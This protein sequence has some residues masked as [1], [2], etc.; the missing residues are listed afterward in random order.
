V[1]WFISIYFSI[2]NTLPKS[3]TF[4]LGHPVYAVAKGITD[5]CGRRVVED[6]ILIHC[7][8][9]IFVCQKGHKT[10]LLMALLFWNI[11]KWFF[12]Q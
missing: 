10:F 1:F 11:F 7:F 9:N 3:G 5:N 12:E 6:T 4:L 2:R 8:K